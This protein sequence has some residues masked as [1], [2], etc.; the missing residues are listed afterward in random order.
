MTE[1]MLEPADPTCEEPDAC[2]IEAAK[3]AEASSEQEADTQTAPM[4]GCGTCGCSS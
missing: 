4:C 2:S 1:A 3:L